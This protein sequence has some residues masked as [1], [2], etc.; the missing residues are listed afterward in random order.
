MRA[1]QQNS[2]F[3]QA[4]K[5]GKKKVELE[6]YE[7]EVEKSDLQRQIKSAEEELSQLRSELN[8][9][10]GSMVTRIINRGKVYLRENNL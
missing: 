1:K 9:G 7:K 2:D 4:L 5:K 3:L 8:S 6:L 10:E